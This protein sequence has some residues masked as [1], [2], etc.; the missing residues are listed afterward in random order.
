MAQHLIPC[1][2][3][4]QSCESTSTENSP[5]SAQKKESTNIFTDP[6]NWIDANVCLAWRITVHNATTREKEELSVYNQ[7][8]IAS[9]RGAF[10]RSTK[11]S[12]SIRLFYVKGP[13]CVELDG[14]WTLQECVRNRANII[15]YDGD[16]RKLISKSKSLPGENC[17]RNADHQAQPKV[18]GK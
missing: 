18:N 16:M 15:A 14:S 9:V 8:D 5:K 3:V 10:I 1:S 7:D 2:C 12:N 6:N 17:Q 13:T 4:A 11:C